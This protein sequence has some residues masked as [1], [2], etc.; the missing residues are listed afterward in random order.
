M[1]FFQG[2]W[3][4]FQKSYD[5]EEIFYQRAISVVHLSV[6]VSVFRIACELETPNLAVLFQ[7]VHLSTSHY[8]NCV[9]T[10]EET[11]ETY[12]V[13]LY[14]YGGLNYYVTMS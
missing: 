13:T 14:R 2:F 7:Y 4:H 6:V 1:F 5:L 10:Q 3:P 11:S 8:K 9:N 12:Y